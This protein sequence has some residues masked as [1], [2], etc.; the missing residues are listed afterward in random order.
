L[1]QHYLIKI[2][3]PWGYRVFRLRLTPPQILMASL[4]LVV[5]LSGACGFYMWQM[6]HA[7]ARVGQLRDL[8]VEQRRQLE[9]IDAEAA[10]LDSKLRA[11]ERQNDEIRG[12]MGAGKNTHAS[13]PG[14]PLTALA[15][16]GEAQPDEGRFAAVA[17]RVDSLNRRSARARS[18]STHLRTLALHVLNM[19]RL[20]DLARA[21]VLAAIPSLNPVESGVAGIASPFGW[22]FSPW[23]EFHKGV[24]LEADYEPVRASAAGTVVA[25]GYEGGYGIKVDID[26]GNG[27][28]TWYCHLSRADVA[29]GQYVRK[30]QHIAESGSTGESTGP[31]LHY[32]IMLDGQAIDP[33]PYLNGVPPKVLASLK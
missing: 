25:A 24:D 26:H 14:R 12:L 33:A 16:G 22:R 17:A 9:K 28:H 27:Y 13:A 10:D 1:K 29:V 15:Q 18:E 21:R 19:H 2:V 11:L 32:Q 4:A 3:P 8:T 20:E 23:P 30:A 31:H 5:V 6:L 7:E